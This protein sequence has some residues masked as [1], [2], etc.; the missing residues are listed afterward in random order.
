MIVWDKTSIDRLSSLWATG[1]SSGTIAAEFG[2]SRS[3]ICGKI[4]RLGLDKRTR[5][6][7]P[8][9]GR[10]PAKPRAPK[11]PKEPKPE[12]RVSAPTLTIR[13]PEKTTR[14]WRVT[15]YD[16]DVVGDPAMVGRPMIGAQREQCRFPIDG[17]APHLCCAA[18][19]VDGHSWCE[20]HFRVV[21]ATRRGHVHRPDGGRDVNLSGGW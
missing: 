14:A 1:A 4:H 2:T 21:Y 19:V 13:A 15:T 20:A 3:A 10:S 12:T 5:R 7:L 8:R 11:L 9:A 6:H 18:P 17:H 16:V